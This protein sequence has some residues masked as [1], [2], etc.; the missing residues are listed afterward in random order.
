MVGLFFFFVFIAEPFCAAPVADGHHGHDAHVLGEAEVCPHHI[1]VK[2]AHRM[3]DETSL[4]CFKGQ[5]SPCCTG[6]ELVP[7]VL[8][9]ALTECGYSGDHH[10][11]GSMHSPFLIRWC[12]RS[13]DESFSLLIFCDEKTP[14]LFVKTRRCITSGF[15]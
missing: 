3:S 15:Y 7:T 14:R 4:L 1:H 5:V 12:K 2:T 9:T 13:D 6:V 11:Y 8:F 10:Q